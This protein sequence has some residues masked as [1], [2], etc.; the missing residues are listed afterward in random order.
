M[1]TEMTEAQLRTRLEALVQHLEERKQR[2]V[3]LQQE[4]AA[5]T[6]QI[7]VIQADING[8]ISEMNKLKERRSGS[9]LRSILA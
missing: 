5:I 4:L 6:Q 8:A 1:T 2:E 7:Y 9:F 3:Q